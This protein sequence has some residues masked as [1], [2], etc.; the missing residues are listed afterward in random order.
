MHLAEREMDRGQQDLHGAIA[1]RP[2]QLELCT[3]LRL[4]Q[5]HV[6]A[7]RFQGRT[8]VHVSVT[9]AGGVRPDADEG[10]SFDVQDQTVDARDHVGWWRDLEGD[11]SGD[12]DPAAARLGDAAGREPG[13]RAGEDDAAHRAAPRTSAFTIAPM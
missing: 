6:F 12:L 9:A 5:D 3:Q 8:A 7:G 10:H 2:D 13:D 11:G 1:P 4:G